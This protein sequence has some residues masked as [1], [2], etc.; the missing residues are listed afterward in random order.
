MG[1]RTV[2]LAKA[3]EDR[4]SWGI[5]NTSHHISIEFLIIKNWPHAKLNNV[6]GFVIQFRVGIRYLICHGG[7]FDKKEFKRNLA[8]SVAYAPLLLGGGS[9]GQHLCLQT[10]SR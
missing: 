6:F 5:S 9:T 1:N 10:P 2:A 7:E 8:G 3:K 4:R